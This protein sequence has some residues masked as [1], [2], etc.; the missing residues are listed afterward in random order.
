MPKALARRSAGQRNPVWPI[1]NR[2]F[3]L[4]YLR[5]WIVICLMKKRYYLQ[6][7]GEVAAARFATAR[8]WHTSIAR[9]T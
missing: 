7:A 1:T 5:A 9:S 3:G 6:R 2:S 8:R 4:D